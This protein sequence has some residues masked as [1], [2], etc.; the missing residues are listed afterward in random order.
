VKIESTGRLAALGWVFLIGLA[1][2]LPYSVALRSPFVFDDEKLV[3]ENETI[4]DLRRMP[5]TFD[6]FS[7]RWDALELRANYR[8]LRFL[9]YAIDYQITRWIFGDFRPEALPTVVFHVHNLVL[10]VLNALLLVAIGRRL[11]GDRAA[12]LVLGLLFA[13]HPLMTEA[14]T[15]VSGRRDVLSAF[16]F[17]TALRLTLVSDTR[18]KSWFFVPVLFALGLLSKEMVVTLPAVI[19]LVD[20]ARRA[21]FDAPRIALHAVL[22]AMALGFTAFEASSPRLVAGAAGGSALS[23]ALTAP[24][25]IARYL[26]LLLFPRGLSLDYSYDAIP[27]STGLLDPATTLPAIVLAA[28][29][30]GAGI[31]LLA[32]RRAL[33]AIGI[34]WFLGTLAP[35]LQ[36]VPIPERFAERFVYLPAI[37]VLL[38]GAG[39][40][41]AARRAHPAVAWTAAC[42]VLVVLGVRTGFRNAEWTK[43]LDLWGSA[44]RTQPRCARARLAHAQALSAAD[45]YGEAVDEATAAIAILGDVPPPAIASGRIEL[46]R[47][48]ERLRWGQVLRARNLRAEAQGALGTESPDRFRMAAEDYR[49]IL[50]QRDSDGTPIGPSPRFLV[51]RFN[52]AGCLLGQAA[53]EQAPRAASLRAEAAAEFR[54]VAAGSEPELARRSRYYLAKIAGAEGRADDELAEMEEAFRLARTPI[55][56]YYLAGELADLLVARKEADRA[57]ALL[58]ATIEENRTLPDRKHLLYRRSGIADRRGDLASAVGILEEAL[59]IDPEFAPALLTLAGME[60]TRGNLDR[61]EA[62]YRRLLVIAPGEG[63]ALQGLRSIEVRRGV[64]PDPAAAAAGEMAA[65]LKGLVERGEGHL[66]KGELIAAGQAFGQAMEKASEAA[67]GEHRELR[68]RTFRRLGNVARELREFPKAERYFAQALEVDPSCRDALVDMGDLQLRDLRNPKAAEDAYRRAI[69]SLPP[70]ASAEVHV[71]INLAS[72]VGE[73]DPS[74]A[75]DLL[76]GALR[77][78]VKDRAMARRIHRTL[79]YNLAR[80]GVWDEALNQFEEFLEASETEAPDDPAETA[81]RAETRRFIEAQVLPRVK[82]GEDLRPG[83]GTP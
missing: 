6:I 48:D 3:L 18:R 74:R 29:L 43:P 12:A 72:L 54:T 60:E 41:A 27:S 76:R 61:A 49:W 35:V 30:A 31:V 25:Y 42:T 78:G 5:E 51:V 15:Y 52:L 71:S 39:L 80:T 4:R 11:L 10:H 62:L 64:A 24:R 14:V 19:L 83:G 23:T 81:E 37:G 53:A 77:A 9:S 46:A 58:V 56:R 75:I 55:D 47:S 40:F 8:P 32:R 36:I 69:E 1:A 34:L 63:K 66:A 73:R 28:G 13:L 7:T 21:K 65:V 44:A 50:A 45:R 26:G 20:L 33:A 82:G 70:G 38:L 16:F 59:A 79:G 22:W 17:L 68:A 67:P 2:C 57:D